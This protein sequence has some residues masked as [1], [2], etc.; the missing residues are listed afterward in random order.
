MGVVGPPPHPRGTAKQRSSPRLRHDTLL[1]R[2]LQQRAAA[3]IH[4]VD[5]R[6]VNGEPLGGRL[7][8]SE[9]QHGAPAFG[10]L[11]TVPALPATWL[12]QYT[13]ASSTAIFS[14]EVVEASVVT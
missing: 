6:R 13:F 4:P 1:R 2:D 10:T 12:V 14:G 9:R 7:A 11:M 8:R 3:R 5:A